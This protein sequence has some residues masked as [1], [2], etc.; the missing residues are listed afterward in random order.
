MIATDKEETAKRR[1]RSRGSTSAP[2]LQAMPDSASALSSGSDA[3]PGAGSASGSTTEHQ[4]EAVVESANRAGVRK[5]SLKDF[6]HEAWHLLEPVSPLVWNWHLDLICEYLTL[7]RDENFKNKCGD[8]EGIIFNV[9]PRT[10]KSLLISV[11]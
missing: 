5:L 6:A 11:F 3:E 10:M 2:Q 9:P 7:I 8:L 4:V 1:K